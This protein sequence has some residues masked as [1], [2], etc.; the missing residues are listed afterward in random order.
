MHLAHVA[1]CM[2]PQPNIPHGADTLAPS[3]HIVHLSEARARPSTSLSQIYLKESTVTVQSTVE[4]NNLRQLARPA[5]CI[6]GRIGYGPKGMPQQQTLHARVACHSKLR[7]PRHPRS[8][9]GWI[10]CIDPLNMTINQ[11]TKCAAITCS[12]HLPP[13]CHHPRTSLDCQRKQHRKTLR[14]D[15]AFRGSPL[16]KYPPKYSPALVT[17]NASP[18]YPK[19]S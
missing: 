3:L 2:L 7:A 15:L 1:P 14:R 11:T 8:R 5:S 6:N 18:R 17:P 10:Y 16:Q 13:W 19:G 4:A 9:T 12:L